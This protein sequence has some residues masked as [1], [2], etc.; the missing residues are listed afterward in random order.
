MRVGRYR[1]ARCNNMRDKRRKWD[2]PP[3]LDRSVGSCGFRLAHAPHRNRF[4]FDIIVHT[5]YTTRIRLRTCYN[6]NNNILCM[7]PYACVGF[8]YMYEQ[9]QRCCVAVTCKNVFDRFRA[10]ALRRRNDFSETLCRWNS[11][12]NRLNLPPCARIV[13][14]YCK[15]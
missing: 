15:R 2:L 6:N 9:Q 13:C 5:V 12:M 3:R 1:Y 10:N 14:D 11:E 7:W 4:S 8:S